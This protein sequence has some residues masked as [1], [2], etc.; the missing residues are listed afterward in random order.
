MEYPS[1]MFPV[2]FT[3]AWSKGALLEAE[4]CNLMAMQISKYATGGDGAQ[5]VD[6]QMFLVLQYL[7]YGTYC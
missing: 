6:M 3:S 4:H 2:V 5:F 7:Y 1:D